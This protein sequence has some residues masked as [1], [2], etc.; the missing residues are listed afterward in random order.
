MSLFVSKVVNGFV[1]IDGKPAY[2]APVSAAKN[3]SGR[4]TLFLPK[5]KGRPGLPADFPPQKP[6]A[7]PSPIDAISQMRKV[8]SVRRAWL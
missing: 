7:A 1:M 2:A 4:T 8:A 5:A 3:G 6:L